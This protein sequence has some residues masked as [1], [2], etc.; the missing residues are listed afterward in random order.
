[1]QEGDLNPDVYGIDLNALGLPAEPC[2]EVACTNTVS[3]PFYTWVVPKA[4]P[5]ERFKTKTKRGTGYP[6]ILHTYLTTRLR[7]DDI[8]PTGAGPRRRFFC[9][10]KVLRG[11]D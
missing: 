2:L 7:C 9:G 8:E 1:M 10:Q 5:E 6:L 11:A 4:L 3:I